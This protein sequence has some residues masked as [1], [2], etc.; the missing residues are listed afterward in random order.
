MIP[1]Y[2]AISRLRRVP[3]P[4]TNDAV[5]ALTADRRRWIAKRGADMGFEALLAEAIAWLLG[6]RIGVRMP[7]ADAW[8]RSPR[9]WK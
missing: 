5:Y 3:V 9:G 1:T 8:A 4:H 2:P 6:R 7:G